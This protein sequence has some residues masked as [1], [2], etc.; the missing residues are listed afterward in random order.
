MNTADL[1]PF[2]R[3]MSDI[4][5]D[6]SKPTWTS[7]TKTVHV[8]VRQ[9]PDGTTVIA[10]EGTT[11]W[12]EWLVDLLAAEIPFSQDPELGP[13][14]AGMAAEVETVADEI[15]SYV[16]NLPKYY[17]LG[18]SKGAG[19]ALIQAG[20][21]K[22]RGHPPSKVI[23]F[24]A[25]RIGT[26]QMRA[27][28]ADIDITQTITQNVHGKDVITQIPVGPTYVD[29][30]EPIILAVSDSLDIAAKHRIAGVIAGLAA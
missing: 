4:Y 17:L 24:E 28:L 3:I 13:V 5:A 19:E 6:D 23:A 7:L 10:H 29:M 8:F 18:H 30:R 15:A 16:S 25:P 1:L 12:Q 20:A 14:H 21:Q 22:K 9:H 2:A 26:A 11:D 27:Y